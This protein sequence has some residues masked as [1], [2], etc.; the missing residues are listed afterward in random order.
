MNF[1]IRI[2]FRFQNLKEKH[3][4]AKLCIELYL[5]YLGIQEIYIFLTS[6]TNFS[7]LNVRNLMKSLQMKLQKR[8]A[9]TKTLNVEHSSHFRLEY[10]SYNCD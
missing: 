4:R 6:I 10:D 1:V 9:K 2:K 5:N 8:C 3:D 7:V